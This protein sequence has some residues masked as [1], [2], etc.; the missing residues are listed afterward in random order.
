MTVLVEE[1]G[2]NQYRRWTGGTIRGV[3]GTTVSAPDIVA[4][5]WDDQKLAF[6]HLYRPVPFSP[7]SGMVRTGTV[8]YVRNGNLIYED[9][10]LA[11]EP[12]PD[13]EIARL[14][15]FVDDT[16]PNTKAGDFIAQ[17]NVATPAQIESYVRSHLNADA[18]VD[19]ATAKTFCK[20][21]ETAIVQL[22]KAL[23]L[24]A[25]RRA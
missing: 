13:P 4:D 2:T 22:M 8:R 23:V 10:D 1:I 5:L 20:R 15:A 16:D 7:P 14:Q 21:T 19:L 18:V 12:P 11:P 17:L 24:I 6:Y 25:K 9:Y 3:D